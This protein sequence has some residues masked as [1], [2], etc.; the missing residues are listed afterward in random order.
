MADTPAS[1]AASKS[2]SA[3]HSAAVS[4]A[5]SKAASSTTSAAASKAAS[6][7]PSGA[8]SKEQS[9]STSRADSPFKETP[10]KHKSIGK[11]RKPD[12]LDFKHQ[13]VLAGKTFADA[14]GE[15]QKP[16]K[17]L[18]S[19][20]QWEEEQRSRMQRDPEYI[21]R[22][23]QQRHKLQELSE[24]IEICDH[25]YSRLKSEGHS[26]EALQWLER[27]V[28][29][30][31]DRDG[32]GT[33]EVERAAHTLVGDCNTIGMSALQTKDFALA[34][35]LLNKALLL[36]EPGGSAQGSGLMRGEGHRR[37]LR[38]ITYNN[39]GCY[40][41]KRGKLHSALQMLDKAL[42]LELLSDQVDTPAT[43]HLNLSAV[44]S[45]LRK[46]RAALEHAQCAV[47]LL[48]EASGT[49]RAL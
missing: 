40:F 24:R 34:H 46:H 1:K 17:K 44:L 6:K 23:E 13:N 31:R 45:Q 10:A 41:R 43:T 15:V 11:G 47:E 38:A 28:W 27:G 48:Q 14:E 3:A 7:L 4:A 9:R 26:L 8:T 2:T 12:P 32:V 33:E 49:R 20:R 18:K 22:K 37:R 16:S 29:L 39:L 5:G 25:E 21:A 42:R 30:R 36:T 19:R 35:E